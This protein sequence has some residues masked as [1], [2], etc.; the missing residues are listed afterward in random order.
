[1][2][3]LSKGK[4]WVLLVIA[5]TRNSWFSSIGRACVDNLP[6]FKRRC[7]V[8]S[9][10]AV[11]AFLPPLFLTHPYMSVCLSACRYV[12]MYIYLFLCLYIHLFLK[13]Q[14][15]KRSCLTD[16]S[17]CCDAGKCWEWMTLTLS[18]CIALVGE[19]EKTGSW[20]K[21][22]CCQTSL[23]FLLLKNLEWI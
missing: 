19:F 7:I 3:F 4:W 5:T 1:M 13:G 12:C 11:R 23:H 14:F 15:V 17:D 21:Y 16:G 8:G 6:T 2:F 18:L 22:E 20:K 10:D 9:H